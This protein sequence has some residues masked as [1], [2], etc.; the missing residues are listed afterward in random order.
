MCYYKILEGEGKT[1]KFN[2]QPDNP[3]NNEENNPRNM[4]RYPS[5][6][7]KMPEYLKLLLKIWIMW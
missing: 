7:E 6:L 1:R 4:T 5:R 3:T 2:T